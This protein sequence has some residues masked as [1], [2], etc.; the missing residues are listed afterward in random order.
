[1]TENKARQ[2]REHQPLTDQ[3]L[4]MIVERRAAARRGADDRELDAL[5]SVIHGAEWTAADVTAALRPF[6]YLCPCGA[7]VPAEK[8]C[9]CHGR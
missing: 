8:T 3:Q 7:V 1:M 4:E 2:T 6:D 5:L 9:G